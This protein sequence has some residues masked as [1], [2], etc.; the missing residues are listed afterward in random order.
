[1]Y[2]FYSF[3]IYS[4]KES[5][6]SESMFCLHRYK[7]QLNQFYVKNMCKFYHNDFFANGSVLFSK[8]SD[9]F[10]NLSLE[11]WIYRNIDLKDRF[12]LLIWINGPAI[13]FG[14]HQN[15]WCEC[16][17]NKC[18]DEKISIARR[19]SGGGTVFHDFGNMNLSFMSSRKAYN[20]KE[21]LK[22]IKNVLYNK[23]NI[24]CIITK[25]ED[26]VLAQSGHKISGTASKLG[27]TNAYHHCTLLVDVDLNQMRKFIRKDAVSFNS[28]TIKNIIL[29]LKKHYFIIIK[30]FNFW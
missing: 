18:M 15:P 27:S 4:T 3:I 24:D 1:M 20:R 10:A 16:N 26:L 12:L 11:D 28:V 19:N 6:L 14:R 2:S 17:I 25:R 5:T 30:I 9:I 29:L 21:N 23:W 22:I 7:S 8:S 13:V